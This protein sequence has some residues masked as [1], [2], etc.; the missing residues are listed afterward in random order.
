MEADPLP[1]IIRNHVLC[2]VFDMLPDDDE[3]EL[4]F[5]VIEDEADSGA[6]SVSTSPP[7]EKKDPSKDFP[8]VING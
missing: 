2:E 6:P 5:R 8:E 3:D 7:A 1:V 4:P